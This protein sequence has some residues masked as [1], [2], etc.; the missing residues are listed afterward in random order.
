MSSWAERAEVTALSLPY[1][2][3]AAVVGGRGV[4]YMYVDF[5]LQVGGPLVIPGRAHQAAG[6]I[7]QLGI[8]FF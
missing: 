5:G 7:A 2:Y 4:S 1:A 6:L 3:V 8:I